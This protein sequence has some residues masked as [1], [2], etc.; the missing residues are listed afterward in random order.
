MLLCV[1]QCDYDHFFIKMVIYI[2]K[3][4]HI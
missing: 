4:K 1:L 3:R 2:K